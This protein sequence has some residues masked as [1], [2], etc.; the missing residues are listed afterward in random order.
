[1]SQ[2][3]DLSDPYA[4]L[5]KIVKTTINTKQTAEMNKVIC[6]AA[7]EAIKL[8]SGGSLVNKPDID[9]KVNIRLL[10]VPGGAQE[11]TRLIPGN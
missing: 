1:M 8:I 7:I 2:K 4:D 11:E 6:T 5:L 10:Q 3:V 9:I